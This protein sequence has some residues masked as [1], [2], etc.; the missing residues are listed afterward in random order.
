MVKQIEHLGGLAVGRRRPGICQV[1]RG[2]HTLPERAELL[3][4]RFR[5]IASEGNGLFLRN[6]DTGL[7]RKLFAEHAVVAQSQER[8]VD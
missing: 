5:R 2:T 8:D 7:E 1:R 6:I 4:A 3:Q